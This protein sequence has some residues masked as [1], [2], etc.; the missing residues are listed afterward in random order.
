MINW[1]PKEKNILPVERAGNA[2]QR[3]SDRHAGVRRACK[4]ERAVPSQEN[5]HLRSRLC[6]RGLT[7]Q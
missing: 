1:V 6:V 5:A 2:P 4:E 7:Q 3:E